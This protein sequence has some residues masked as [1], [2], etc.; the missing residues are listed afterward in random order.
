LSKM[1]DSL[2]KWILRY[3]SGRTW[4]NK[5]N[6]EVTKR[7]YLTHLKRYCNEVK[8][9]PDEL[10]QLKIDGLKHIGEPSEYQA[11]NL[12]ETYLATTKLTMNM[13]VSSKT[14]VLSFYAKNRRR[15]DSETA[16]N[17]ERDEPQKRCPKTNDLIELENAMNTQ[18]DKAVLWF[19]ASAP[20]RV[21]SIPKLLW[22]DLKPTHDEDV[23]YYLKIEGKRLKGSGKGKYKGVKQVAFLHMLAVQKL[24]NYRVEAK[25]R[26]YKLNKDSP[27]FISYRQ[28]G[29][30]KPLSPYSIEGVFANASLAAWHNLEQKRFSPHDL[31]DYVQS[32]L[33]NAGVNVNIIKP[34]LAHKPRGVDKHYS[35]HDIRDFLEKFKTALPY[36]LPQSVESVKAEMEMTRAEYEVTVGNLIQTIVSMREDFD[37]FKKDVDE[38]LIKIDKETI[39]KQMASSAK[40][41]GG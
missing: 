18:R 17:I 22:K 36:L 5:L 30:L 6:S 28:Q 20:V 40:N 39:K 21:G 29:K 3:P 26:G 9:N 14:A 32:A 41:A 8:K 4:F 35:E 16:E 37:E 38:Y 10:I 31:R 1:T 7:I 23:P 24:R 27:I 33:E 19:I 25:E 15:L 11:E 13:K 12:L 34:I 2:Q